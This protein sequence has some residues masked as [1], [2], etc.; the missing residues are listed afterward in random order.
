M[1]SR[2]NNKPN[3]S[4]NKLNT[5]D[6]ISKQIW[7]SR[8]KSDRPQS[9]KLKPISSLKTP[10]KPHGG[11]WTSSYTPDCE[12]DCDWIRWSSVEEYKCGRHKW[13]MYPEDNLNILVIDSESDLNSIKSRYKKNS[14]TDIPW[15]NNDNTA[16]D[17][18]SISGDFDAIRLTKNGLKD[19]RFSNLGFYGWD[20]ECVLSFNW[21]WY[22]Y[23]YI[24]EI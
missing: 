21:N 2:Y 17:F 19:T 12:Y 5:S 6:Q 15:T 9:E 7:V 3:S 18:K 11:M 23:E 16:I 14:Q 4:K 1:G 20:C 22:D 24:G 13:L 8:E 10:I